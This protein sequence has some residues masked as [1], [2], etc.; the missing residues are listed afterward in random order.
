MVPKERYKPKTTTVQI[1]ERKFLAREMQEGF[2]KEAAE[3]AGP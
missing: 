2:M 3:P 1:K